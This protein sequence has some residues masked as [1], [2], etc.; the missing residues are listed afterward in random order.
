MKTHEIY[1]KEVIDLKLDFKLKTNHGNLKYTDKDNIV[2]LF[3]PL[4]KG[5]LKL[6]AIYRDLR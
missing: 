1:R 6:I 5:E 4:R 3:E 2:Y